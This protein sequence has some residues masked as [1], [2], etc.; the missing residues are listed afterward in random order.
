MYIFP[1][2]LEGMETDQDEDDFLNL[3]DT[4]EHHRV[5]HLCKLVSFRY[6]LTYLTKE[7]PSV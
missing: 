2:S 6:E 5:R 3:F 7:F 4:R 1:G